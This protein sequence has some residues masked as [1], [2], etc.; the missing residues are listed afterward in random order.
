M[1]EGDEKVRGL[2]AIMDQYHPCRH[3]YYNPAATPRTAV[4]C[5]DVETVT[6]KRK[7]RM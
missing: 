1:V 2:D 3:A 5:L 6:G 7:Q 4:Y